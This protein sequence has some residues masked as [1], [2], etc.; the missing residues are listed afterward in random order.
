MGVDFPR[1]FEARRRTAV[2]LLSGPGRGPAEAQALLDWMER[3]ESAW[4][5]T[6]A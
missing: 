6:S 3:N 5:R 2:D 4:R 1:I